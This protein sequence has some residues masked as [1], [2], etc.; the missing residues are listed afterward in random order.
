MYIFFSVNQ[1][2]SIFMVIVEDSFIEVQYKKSY[3]WLRSGEGDA[4]QGG[5]DDSPDKGG[6]GKDGGKDTEKLALPTPNI[7]VPAFI[8][9]ETDP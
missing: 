1:V 2:Q 4:S 7:V 5:D 9:S 8:L 3:E 6:G